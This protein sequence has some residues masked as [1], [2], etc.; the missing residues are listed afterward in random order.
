MKQLPGKPFGTKD[1]SPQGGGIDFLGLRWV[2]LT[3]V[4]RDLIPE[5]NNVTT[6]M[7]AFFLAAWIPWKFRQLCHDEKEYTEDKY[8]AFREKV[9]VALSLTLQDQSKLNRSCGIVRN[10]VGITQSCKMPAILN[11]RSAHRNDTNSLY[12][13]AIYGPSVHALGLIASYRSKTL[14]KGEPLNIAVPGDDQDVATMLA[15]VDNSLKKSKSYGLLASLESPSF[16]WHDICAL[17][18]AGLDPAQ[19]RA[20]EYAPLKAAFARKLLPENR[21]HVGYLRTLTTRL[22]LSTIRQNDQ[23]TTEEMRD[24]WYTGMFSTG[25]SLKLMDRELEKQRV[26][27]ACLMA[28]QYQRYAIELFLWCF[29]DALKNGSR[30]LDDAVDYWAKRSQ[31]AGKSLEGTFG[32][33]LK[34]RAGRLFRTHELLT[35]ET[36]NNEVHPGD[37]RFEYVE[38]PKGDGAVFHGFDMLAGWYWR[39]LT[40]QKR[41]VVKELLDLGG[42]DRMSMTWFLQWL[43]DR[44]DR[45]LRELLK[46]VFSQLI[47]AQHIRIALARFDGTAQRLRFLLG[48][49][50]IEPTVSAR[51]DLGQLNLPWMPD[52]LDTLISLLCD[53]DILAMNEKI[54][55][56]GRRADKLCEK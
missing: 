34:T 45:S 6:D 7:G 52:R 24:T 32:D 17:G 53:C 51:K 54:L 9:E 22:I 46:D 39:I 48:D 43:R 4:G 42:S 10:R 56:V 28:R 2:N 47:F 12:A 25:K 30:S 3:I 19:Y 16:E 49:S 5:L 40:W 11:F 14:V 18:Q 26:R 33:T 55:N 35:S 27:W 38:D 13:A 1:F 37:D 44:Q 41:D 15:G 8:R 21:Q 36:W 29:E 23:L 20:R 31:L 50:G